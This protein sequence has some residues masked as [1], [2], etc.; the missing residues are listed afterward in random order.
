MDHILVIFEEGEISMEINWLAV[1]AWI[2]IV[3]TGIIQISMYRK[4]K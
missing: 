2:M 3:I 1:V 4:N